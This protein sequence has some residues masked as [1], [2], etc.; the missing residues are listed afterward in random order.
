MLCQ[1]REH[2][3][4]QQPREDDLTFAHEQPGEAGRAQEGFSS[5]E[6][7]GS[8]RNVSLGKGWLCKLARTSPEQHCSSPWCHYRGENVAAREVTGCCRAATCPLQDSKAQGWLW[9][10]WRQKGLSC[11]SHSP[12]SL[13][14]LHPEVLHRS[15]AGCQDWAAVTKEP[16]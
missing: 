12:V 1:K 11:R 15:C 3:T 4:R 6:D 7:S 13:R 8:H 10:S 14:V 2:K 9:K 16:G 5:C